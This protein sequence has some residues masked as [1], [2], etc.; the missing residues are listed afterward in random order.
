MYD[1]AYVF[2]AHAQ[3]GSDDIRCAFVNFAKIV[4][5]RTRNLLSSTRSTSK[6]ASNNDY[7]LGN[8]NILQVAEEYKHQDNLGMVI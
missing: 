7:D 2:V 3:I 1:E 4:L 5:T 6:N 8:C